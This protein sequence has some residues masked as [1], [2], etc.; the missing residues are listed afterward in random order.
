VVGKYRVV[1]VVVVVVVV[2]AGLVGGV[3]DMAV[4]KVCCVVVAL[5]WR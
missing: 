5:S 4:S 3:V 2:G 1:V